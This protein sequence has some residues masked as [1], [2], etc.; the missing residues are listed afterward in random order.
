RLLH[1]RARRQ[2][3]TDVTVAAGFD[4]PVLGAQTAFRA[5]MD[6][7]ARPG[8]IRPLAGLAGAPAP[9]S[10]TA[11][12]LALTLLDYETPF[13]L[14]APLAP[15]PQAAR[16]I[17]SPTAAAL[18]TDPAEAAFAFIA[19]PVAVPPFDSFALGTPEFPDRSATLVLQ[20]ASLD[21]GTA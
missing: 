3:V 6:A 19:D 4:A 5:V 20:V 10:P 12:A 13:W 17:A 9:L 16:W 18:A 11:A 21:A 15:A 2:R 1:P 14:D 7:M 8:T